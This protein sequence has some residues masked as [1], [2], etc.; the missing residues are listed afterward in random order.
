[1]PLLQAVV[2]ACDLATSAILVALS[3]LACNM[4]YKHKGLYCNRLAFDLRNWRILLHFGTTVFKRGTRCNNICFAFY[5]LISAT[6]NVDE[7]HDGK[8]ND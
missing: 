1:M 2:H 5:S 3:T 6:L 4:F 8:P 7:K